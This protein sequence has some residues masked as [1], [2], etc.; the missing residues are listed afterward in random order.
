[1]TKNNLEAAL[2]Y[3]EH[4][5]SVIP[6]GQDKKPKMKVK[7]FQKRRANELEVRKW[8]T[9]WPDANVGIITGAISGIVVVDIE[10]GGPTNDL[11]PTVMCS[12]G[13]GG[14]HFYY[15]YP[16]NYVKNGVRVKELTDIR[17]D[18][19][20]VVAP[21]SL[22]K[23][24]KNYEWFVAPGDADFADLPDWVLERSATIKPKINLE[25]KLKE[26]VPDGE[27]HNA[28][29]QLAGKY[30]RELP[31]QM[32]K[33][34]G[35]PALQKWNDDN[36]LPPLEQADLRAVWES[37]QNK[38]QQRRDLTS[39]NMNVAKSDSE[40][41]LW[42]IDE[43][44]N[45]DFGK[46]EWLIESLLLK[47]GLMALSGNPGDY[48]TALALYFALSVARG[49]PVFGKF[50]ATAGRVLMIDEENHLRNIKKRF[51]ALG[52]VAGEAVLYL[53]QNEIKVDSGSA[54]AR[55]LK[56]IEQHKIALVTLDS[57][58]DIHRQE[59]NDSGG[60]QLVLSAMRQF[61]K[62]GASVIFLHHPTKGGFG[63]GQNLRGSSNILAQVDVHLHVE[64]K[65][66]EDVLILKQEKMRDAPKLKPFEVKIVLGE[67]G[68]SDFVFA[69][70]Q[71]EKE[72]K[73]EDAAKAIE[74]VLQEIAIQ[75][76]QQLIDALKAQYGRN[77][78]DDGIKFALEAKIL[79]LVPKDELPNAL[80][81][82]E[83]RQNYYRLFSGGKSFKETPVLSL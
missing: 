10:A 57:F 60:M 34:A 72:A 9:Q 32:W 68:P 39:E 21:P 53:S 81:P 6:V 73:A 80:T 31:F 54:V 37:I 63:G 20:Y 26:K 28:A 43:I 78:V 42:T 5:W 8:F 18:G 65:R 14:W 19:G 62:A 49:T 16:D 52:G 67:K 51:E 55:V 71:N 17:G 36:C 22:H 41:H 70:F 79:E 58:V 56:L 29:A 48:K 47:P 12:T 83:K 24:G 64:K 7:E 44:L 66:D 75:S 50:P 1:M 45:H 61:V 27:R 59:E 77:A 3:L 74:E 69:D 30:L 46:D 40:W 2:E 76:R 15:K 25:E 35:W 23:S 13:G 11:P 33:T 82:N 4:G 38:E